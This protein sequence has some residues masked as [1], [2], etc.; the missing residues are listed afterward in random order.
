MDELLTMTLD[1]LGTLVNEL[2][3]IEYEQYKL[4]WAIAARIYKFEHREKALTDGLKAAIKALEYAEQVFVDGGYGYSTAAEM[5]AWC[6]GYEGSPDIR[7]L[8]KDG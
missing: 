6:N 7:E 1:E 5:W 8:V 3:E 4:K 2:G